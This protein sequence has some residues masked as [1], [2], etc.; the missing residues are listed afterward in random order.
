MGNKDE[1]AMAIFC[2]VQEEIYKALG[3]DVKVELLISPCYRGKKQGSSIKLSDGIDFYLLE[4]GYSDEETN[5]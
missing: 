3:P 1:E 2:I 5:Y 4:R